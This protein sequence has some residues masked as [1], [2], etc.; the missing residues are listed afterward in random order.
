M[1]RDQLSIGFEVRDFGAGGPGAVVPGADS[2]HGLPVGRP[3]EVLHLLGRHGAALKAGGLDADVGQLRRIIPVR[4]NEVALGGDVAAVERDA[5]MS[6]GPFDYQRIKPGTFV[7]SRANHE[8]A[9]LRQAP[10]DKLR[11]NG[12]VG[13]VKIIERPC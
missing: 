1:G 10:F 11:A 3:S 7:V 2:Y 8:R 4:G 12:K 5:L 6:P 13:I 9:T